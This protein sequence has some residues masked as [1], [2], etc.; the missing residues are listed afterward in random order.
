MSLGE[1]LWCSLLPELATC[2]SVVPKCQSAFLVLQQNTQGN[3]FQNKKGLF[4]SFGIPVHDSPCCLWKEGVS[5]QEQVRD[6]TLTTGRRQEGEGKDPKI[7]IKGTPLMI[8]RLPGRL[9]LLHS[10]S[11]PSM[12]TSCGP[13]SIHNLQH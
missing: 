11:H 13:A 12:V 7:P 5:Q 6:K 2:E 10:L 4:G 1:R 9:L 3:S 8:R